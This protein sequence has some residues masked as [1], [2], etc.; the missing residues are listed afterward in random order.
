MSFSSEAPRTLFDWPVRVYYEDTDAAG[1]V[2]YANY[3]RFMER[4][5][6]EWL[7]ALGYEQDRLRER[8]GIV[9]AVRRVSLEYLAP[10]RFNDL[11]TVRSAVSALRGASLEF[12]QSVLRASDGTC[13]TQGQVKVAC[14]DAA[15]LRARRMPAELLSGMLSGLVHRDDAFDD[16]AP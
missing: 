4:G 8:E 9:F 5:R 3:L 12:E 11:L 14:L 15:T 13:C 6:T 1:V 10:A 2:F 16:H 7:R